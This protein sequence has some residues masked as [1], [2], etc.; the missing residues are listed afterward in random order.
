M[1]HDILLAVDLLVHQEVAHVR[2][3]ISLQ[4]DDLPQLLVLHDRPVAREAPLPRLQYQ[5]QIQI[6][7]QALHRCD[8]LSPVA[9]LNANMSP[10]KDNQRRKPS[11]YAPSR[12]SS[13]AAS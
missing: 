5:L 8:A 9:L 12:S 4:L 10:V 13:P 11:G 1:D 2:A 7:R 3:L 6:R